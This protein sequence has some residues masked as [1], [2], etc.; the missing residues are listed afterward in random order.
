MTP[1]PLA[2]GVAAASAPNICTPTKTMEPTITKVKAIHN[3]LANTF[4]FNF[5]TLLFK[6][7]ITL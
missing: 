2:T 6:H 3:T 5:L 4:V 7:F 1:E